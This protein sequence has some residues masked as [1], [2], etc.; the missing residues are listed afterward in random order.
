MKNTKNKLNNYIHENKVAFRVFVVSIIIIFVSLIIDIFL[1]SNHQKIS[2]YLCN[3]STEFIGIIV[4]YIVIQNFID[5]QKEN[6]EKQE[7]LSKILR[8]NGLVSIYL[9]YYKRFFY[10]VTTPIEKRNFENIKI[11]E[12]FALKDMCDLYKMSLLTTSP[13]FKSSIEL[14]YNY[15][16]ELRK[17]FENMIN[18]IEFKYF[19]DIQTVITKFINISLGLDV[20]DAILSNKD[21]LTGGKKFI[22]DV[23]EMLKSDY[24]EEHYKKFKQRTLG[25]NAATIY[26]ILYDLMKSELSIITR[27]ENFIKTL[28]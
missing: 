2:G 26:F 11:S 16:Q 7:E 21:I 17:V 25:A 5:K 19:K 18:N 12:T 27:Y 10:C 8:Y 9:N 24:I 22:D 28:K 15:E 6:K 20:K 1:Q 14:F 13:L 3:I 23:N 4:T